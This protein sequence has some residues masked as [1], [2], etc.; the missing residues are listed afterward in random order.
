MQQNKD[1]ERG[2][3]SI[4]A[5]ASASLT[6]ILLPTPQENRALEVGKGLGVTH[7]SDETALFET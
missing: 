1:K 5:R 4:A 2:K 3:Y 6:F 7:Y